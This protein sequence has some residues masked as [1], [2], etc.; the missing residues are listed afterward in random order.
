[1]D[2]NCKREAALKLLASL[3]IRRSRY[4][5]PLLQLLWRLGIDVPPPHFAGFLWNAV[6]TACYFGV[7]WGLFMYVLG[8]LIYGISM[9]TVITSAV[10]FG[11][12]F[13]LY[14]ACYYGYS[15][16]RHRLPSWNDYNPGPPGTS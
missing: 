15:K 10:K 2:T 4:E 3:G 6:L 5:P 13:G 16:W 12:F 14:T 7:A 8:Y 9:T 11:I 1:M